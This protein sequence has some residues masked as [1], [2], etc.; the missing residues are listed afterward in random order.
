MVA[1]RSFHHYVSKRSWSCYPYLGCHFDKPCKLHKSF[2]PSARTFSKSLFNYLCC[3]CR[4][5]TA[6][7]L[8]HWFLCL[9]APLQRLS[10]ELREQCM[11]GDAGANAGGSIGLLGCGELALCTQAFVLLSLICSISTQNATLSPRLV[12]K[13]RSSRFIDRL[14]F[15]QQP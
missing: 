6:G 5:S 11:M 3:S 15:S 7:L 14:G 1:C 4:I 9:Q 8:L 10:D 2:G 12:D 13:I